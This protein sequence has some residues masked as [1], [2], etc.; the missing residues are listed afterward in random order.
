M[1]ELLGSG[2]ISLWLEAIGVYP[3]ALPQEPTPL[4]LLLVE[5][6][7]PQVE[8]I[9]Q[10]YLQGLSQRGFV[11]A[12]QGIWLQSDRSLLTQHV[13][14]E[15]LPAASLTKVATSLVALQ[16]WGP[17][18]QFVTQV[19]ATGAIA[20]GVLQGDL[21]IQGSGDP[22]FVWEEAFSLGNTLNRMG[23]TE[24]KGNLVI[25]GPFA[26][27]YETEPAIAGELLRQALDASLWS[28]EAA[29]QFATLPPGTPRPQVR[30]TGQIK[31]AVLPL[32]QQTLLIQHRSL[33]L[34]ELLKQMN[35]YSNNEIA[36]MLATALG[37]GPTVAHR[38][39][40]MAQ[41]PASE[42]QLINGSGLGHENRISP[43][44]VCG[45]FQALQRQL[46]G[47]QLTVANLFPVMGWDRGTVEFRKLPLAAVVK[48]GT[49]WDVS[50]LAGVI[51]TQKYG[52]VWFAIINRGDDIE[53]FRDQQ[54]QFLR[55]LTQVW[56]APPSL[57]PELRPVPIRDRLGDSSRNQI[58]L[59]QAMD[60]AP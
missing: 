28:G 5:Q 41:V 24:V 56:G 4:S 48:T 18:Y 33:P 9:V 52:P 29:D 50:A 45:M 49:L 3:P 26:M 22:L 25:A 8:S 31:S 30:I 17:Q 46:Q 53:G 14:S 57:L 10:Q 58:L 55:A 60:L 7:Q 47:H 42:I 38:A 6:R 1:L 27:N 11:Q 16:T 21:V 20:N 23:I 34:F 19:G 35:I 13:G 12:G 32:G 44:A 54:D 2:I 39:A 37:G 59:Q 43:R 51:P 15:P 40:I 36:E